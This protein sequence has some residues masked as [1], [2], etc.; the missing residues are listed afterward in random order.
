MHRHASNAISAHFRLRSIGVA[1]DHGRVR[2]GGAG[3]S[4]EQ[5]AIGSDS[6]MTIAKCPYGLTGEIPG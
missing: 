4:N 3:G 1:D 2:T 5:D 6:E